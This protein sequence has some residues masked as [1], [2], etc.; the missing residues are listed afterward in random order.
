MNKELNAGT[1]AD[2]GMQPIVTTSASLAQNPLLAAVRCIDFSHTIG[3][4]TCAFC[5]NE[6]KLRCVWININT[7]GHCCCQRC[8]HKADGFNKWFVEAENILPSIPKQFDWFM[9]MYFKGYTP[10]EA[11]E[12]M[13]SVV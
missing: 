3:E 1:A 2:N 4:E 13:R 9:E 7:T 10:S 8:Y 11:V 5:D 12:A 6:K